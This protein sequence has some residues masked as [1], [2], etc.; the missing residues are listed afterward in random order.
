MTKKTFSK[1]I[2]AVL[3]VS[4]C[5][6]AVFTGA[7]SAAENLTCTVVGSEYDH[8]ATDSYVTAKVTFASTTAF[9]AGAFT[10]SA[11][12]LSLADCE[13]AA[14]EG[15]NNPNIY[16]NVSANK[17]LFAGFEENAVDELRSYTSLTLLLKFTINTNDGKLEKVAK[18]K[19]WTVNVSGV[20]VTSTD[21]KTYES[22]SAT[23][24]I[25]VHNY[26]NGTTSGNIKTTTCSFCGETHKEIVSTS[27]L[28]TNDLAAS[29]Q[30]GAM[31]YFDEEG[32][33]VFNALVLASAVD[34]YENVYF[35]YSYKTD[36]AEITETAEKLE[37]KVTKDAKQYYAFPLTKNI[38]IGRMG[39]PVSGNFIAVAK[40]NGTQTISGE[41][42]YSIK[43]YA[44][45]IISGAYS[46][47][48]KNFAKSLWNYGKYTA[49]YLNLKDATE[50]FSGAAKTDITDWSGSATAPTTTGADGKWKLKAAQVTTGYKPTLKLSFTNSAGDAVPTGISSITIKVEKAGKLLY[51]KTIA[52][53]VMETENS[54]KIYYLS[55]IPTKYLA[56]DITITANGSTQVTTYGFGRYAWSRLNKSGVSQAEKNIIQAMMNYSQYIQY[57]V[58]EE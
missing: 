15:E 58:G 31:V 36:D 52:L 23:G 1:I 41:W 54:R 22:P 44:E 21:E 56:E 6:T 30:T 25:H 51:H 28:S 49:E 47:E 29:N 40:S 5:F 13:V 16:L 39:R 43:D 20:S 14:K 45:N 24:T 37:K 50:Y 27:N 42:S 3:V 57:M 48:Q 4:L 35:V 33:T 12:G 11:D 8:G 19:T 9:T 17:I 10:A 34:D 26:T 32:N 55:D 46:D 38:G 2:A 53:D 7:V 18:G